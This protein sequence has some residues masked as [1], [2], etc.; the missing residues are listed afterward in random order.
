[1]LKKKTVL[2]IVLLFVIV[3]SGCTKE[4]KIEPTS[5]LYRNFST[6]YNIFPISYADSDGDGKGD[7]MGIVNQL[8]YLND[9]DDKTDTDL[10]IDCIW[11]NPIHPS[12]SYHKYDVTDYY[13]IDPVFGTIDDFKLLIQEAEKRNISIIMDYVI[14]HTSSEHEWFKKSRIGDKKYKNWYRW[15]SGDEENYSTLE[16]WAKYGDQYYFA[17]FWDGMP[18]LNFD[19][20]EVR[21]EIKKI[22]KY[23]LE[24]GVDGFRIDAAIHVYDQKEYP[25]DTVVL[26][27]NLNWFKEFNSYI[28]SVKEDAILISEIWRDAG[29]IAYHLEGMD[30]A[31]NFDLSENIISG[32]KNGDARSIERLIVNIFN[33]YKIYK[34]DF[35]DSIFITN[36][37]MNR[38]MSQFGNNEVYAKTAAHMLFTLPGVSWVYYGEELGMTGVKPDENLRE[39][40]KWSE[41]LNNTPNTNW[42]P[43][44]YNSDTPSL[45]EQKKDPES[46]YNKYRTLINLKK[47]HEI[48]QKGVF[49]KVDSKYYLMSY[50]RE[51]DEGKYLVL[52]NLSNKQK[53]ITI[54]GNI[55]ST[56][57]VSTDNNIIKDNLLSMEPLSTVILDVDGLI[58]IE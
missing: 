55:K 8:D 50:T 11:L 9:G 29:T 13:A 14:N 2:L 52:H 10:G 4:Y 16:G 54:K 28:K 42:E 44:K 58:T 26:E 23:W 57:Y 41:D 12:P 7:L 5:T 33:Q 46:I 49:K 27:K 51:T 1:M 48:L 43:I 6:C 15:R 40:F 39:P 35:V 17:S 18:E 20:K 32:I 31:F 37:D 22:A 19:N 30:T 36:H 34:A 3:V 25:T 56:I 47:D 24:M 21:K 53:D 38:A 45:A